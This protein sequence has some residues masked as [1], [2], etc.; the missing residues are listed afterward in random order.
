MTPRTL[1]HT[2]L[3]M[4]AIA[5]VG[6]VAMDRASAAERQIPGVSLVGNG[7][8]H[9]SSVNLAVGQSL[10]YDF[11]RAIKDVLV[12]DPKIANAV[13]RSRT[14]AYIEAN[15]IGAT[16]IVFFDAEGSRWLA[17]TL[18]HGKIIGTAT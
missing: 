11:P 9:S 12:A 8:N 4:A 17:S 1:I 13:I 15:E 18:G 2:A 7:R 16:N 14:R 6:V 10:V 5:A 3:L